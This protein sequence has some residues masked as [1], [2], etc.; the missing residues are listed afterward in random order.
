ML[1]IPSS[2]EGATEFAQEV[3]DE[4][5]ATSDDRA[6]VYAEDPRL[7]HPDVGFRCARDVD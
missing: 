6:K 1:R 4:C 2:A 7:P 3:C 5:L